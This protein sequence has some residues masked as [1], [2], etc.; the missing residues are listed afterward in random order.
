MATTNPTSLVEYRQSEGESRVLKNLLSG[1]RKHLEKITSFSKDSLK[2]SLLEIRKECDSPNWDGYNAEP[3]NKAALQEAGHL[4]DS[5]PYTT[6]LPDVIP[7]PSGGVAFEWHHQRN[8][9]L[10]TVSGNNKINYAAKLTGEP[11]HGNAKFLETIPDQIKK[12]LADNFH[13]SM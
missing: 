11:I 1:V 13:A 6:V 7:T 2:N 5:L 3:I 9:L 12:I 4:I 8:A 10:L